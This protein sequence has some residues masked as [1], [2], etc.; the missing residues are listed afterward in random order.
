MHAGR[1]AALWRAAMA[2]LAACVLDARAQEG[3]P[4]VVSP[5]GERVELRVGQ[6]R[7]FSA[8]MTEPGTQF[9]WSLDGAPRGKGPQ[10]EL[11]PTAAFVGTHEVS[12]TAVAPSMAARHTWVVSV[13]AVGAP[14]I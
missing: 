9:T 4:L 13:A 1:C 8:V 3:T 6:R 14:T 2:V 10:F 11:R 7:A 12:V 5:P